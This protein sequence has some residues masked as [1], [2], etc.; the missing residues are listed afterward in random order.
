MSSTIRIF[1]IGLILL[2]LDIYFYQ[3]IIVIFKGASVSKRNIVFYV[4]W[5]FT[6]LS[7]LMLLTPVFFVFH[8][9]PPFF[10]IYVFAFFLMVVISKLIG[11][12][13]I[14]VDDL[15]RFFRWLFSFI[16]KPA[17]AA[18]VSDVMNESSDKISRL[19]FLN[20]IAVGMAA[21]PFMGFVYGMVK[22]AFNYK[23]H[24][25]KIILP[26]LPASFNGLKI[27]QI[28]DIHA[29]SFVS[30]THLE[31]A[32][33]II[34]EQKADVIFFTGDLVNNEAKEMQPFMDVFNKLKAPM[35]VYS[36]LG[37]HDY[38]DYIQWESPEAKIKNL[39]D[40]KA[41][42]K[43]LGWTLLMNEHVAL[44]N[45]EDTIAV[46]GVEN[47][48]GNLNFPKYG[49]MKKAYAGTEEYPVKLLLSHDP[50]HWNKQVRKFYKDIDVTFSG[51]THGFQ[52]GIEI[53]GWIKWSP[54]QFVYKQWAGLYTEDNQHLYVNRGLGFLGY[55]GRV[56]IM[57]EITVMELFNS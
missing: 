45:G 4:Y 9:L 42:H 13:F 57:P 54:S 29:G 55:P 38:G 14:G 23:I 40:L 48:G 20:Q 25:H 17:N 3:A 56:G 28:S 11:S 34:Q 2:L 6:L 32:V 24:N 37:N 10:R 47:W 19:T 16:V 21:V 26:N 36:T 49:D 53:P 15:L 46:I 30:S 44:K 39:D 33:K 18:V 50:S 31:E 43:N 8:E 52:F 22:G 27:V 51:H 5:G 35:G 7:F 12:V 41:V 1:I